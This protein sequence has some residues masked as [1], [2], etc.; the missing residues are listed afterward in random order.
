MISEC[1]VIVP[2]RSP[3]SMTA[4]PRNSTAGAIEITSV[5]PN[6]RG[7]NGYGEFQVGNYTD[8]RFDGALNFVLLPDKLAVRLAVNVEQRHSFYRDIGSIVTAGNAEP[9]QD[10]GQVDDKD[11]RL[12]TLWKPTENFQALLKLQYTSSED[13]GDPAAVNPT[14]FTV[15]A[16][17]LCPN[18]TAGP[19]CHTTYYAYAPHQPFL[20]NWTPQNGV[21][22][23]L[24]HPYYNYRNGLRLDYTFAN[25]TDLRSLTGFQQT[26]YNTLSDG[27]GCDLPNSGGSYQWIPRDDYYSEEV[28]LVSPT[29]GAFWSKFNYIA[30]ASWFYRDTGVTV[31]GT[32]SSPPYSL[33]APF[34]IQ[35]NN[36]TIARIMGVFGQVSWQMLPTLQL[37]I[38]V[39]QNW[40]NDQLRGTIDQAM[41][42]GI[43]PPT[44]PSVGCFQTPAPAFGYFCATP[45][46][47]APFTDSVP[48]GKI[49]LNWTPVQGQFFYAFYARGYKGGVGIAEGTV[50]KPLPAKAVLPEH[51]NDYEIGWNGTM[52]AGRLRTHLGGYWMVDQNSQQAGLFNP[53]TGSTSQLGNLGS[54]TLKGIEGSLDGRFGGFGVN[55]N[56][57]YE[58][59]TVTGITNVASYALPP[60]VGSKGQCGYPGVNPSAC[61]DYAG[62]TPGDPNYYVAISGE[63]GTAAPEWQG[64]ASVDYRIIVGQGTLDPRVS[65]SYTGK[66]Y[67]SLFEIPYYTLEARHIWNAA[68]TYDVGQWDVEA[69]ANNFTNEV[70]YA[71]IMGGSV[72]YGN[73]E[74]V[75][76]RVRRDF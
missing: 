6:F 1:V 20:L 73:P 37:Q 10:P 13:A 23:A 22:A 24:G 18:G 58:K 56:A 63:T 71:G 30:G 36:D 43:L 11:F 28:D 68:L 50:A 33:A 42:P 38:G 8:K 26:Q 5:N 52:L 60:G 14:P 2:R 39:R 27:C 47:S 12:S 25:G 55:L 51:V 72:F 17:A 15:P 53:L 21:L 74:Q 65:F 35:L 69:Y 70:Y 34:Y 61:F 76:L 16:G 46:Q 32:T 31:A 54:E 3:A 75:G 40:D 64:T 7:T 62:I 4:M 48:T 29:T 41:I 9:L 59:A 57:A 66:Q 19:T 67:A 49:D 44:A 45:N